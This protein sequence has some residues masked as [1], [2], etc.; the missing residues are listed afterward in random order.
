MESDSTLQRRFRV[1][2]GLADLVVRLG[3]YDRAHISR[4]FRQL[5]GETPARY[6]TRARTG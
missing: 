1:Q 3:W 5:L 6:A 2:L 4:D